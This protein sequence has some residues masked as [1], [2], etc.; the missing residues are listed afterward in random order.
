M[1][2]YG[3][4]LLLVRRC[5]FSALLAFLLLLAVWHM[6]SSGYLY[7]KAKLAQY[8]LTRAWHAS[9]YTG[10]NV[11]PWF[12]ADTWPV[13]KLMVPSLD[14]ELIVLAGDNGRTLAFGPGHRFGSAMPGQVGNSVI[15]GHRDTHFRFLRNLALGALVHLQMK[16]GSYR[17][18]EVVDMA[19]VD[20]GVTWLPD[21]GHDVLLTLVT[22]YPFDAV[23]PGGR[24]RYLVLAQAL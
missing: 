6:A 21:S 13:A 4:Q 8:L 22:C 11:K 23:A 14:I 16:D 12:W 10:D 2:V 3:G 20:E 5:I 17:Y 15:S 19:V 1:S 7:A 18:Y 9:I 24:L